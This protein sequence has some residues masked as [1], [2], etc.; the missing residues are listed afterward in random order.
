MKV[1]FVG[2][3]GIGQR[4]LRN[5]KELLGNE[6]E[7]YA[8]RQR[9]Y[10]FVLDNKL[11]IKKGLNLDKHYNIKN[12]NS[13]DE[14]FKKNIDIVFITNPTSMHMEILM[15]AAENKCSIFVEK[16]ISHNL[17]NVDKLVTKLNEYKNITFVGFQNRFHPCIKESKK[18]LDKNV[19]GQIVCV[20]IEIG[21]N[22]RGWHKYEDY[23]KM[24]ASRKD[25]GGGVILSQIH[26][27]DY[28]IWF[29]GMPKCVYAIGGKLSNLEIDV[30]DVASILLNYELNNKNIPV[31]IHEDYIQIP[32]SRKCKIIG[33]KGKIE[34]DL[35][36]STLVY[37]DE[38]GNEMLN[39]VYEFERN[40]MF[41][42]ELK[43]FIDA[44]KDKKRTII[45]I[46]EGIKS[47]KMA[48]AI[49]ESINK[50]NIIN[51]NEI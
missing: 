23:R 4:H 2:L 31:H 19:I 3:G 25:L 38:D 18:L 37:Y 30:E 41:K 1:L 43:V 28:I 49:K 22:V 21:E 46:E 36:N 9:K 32:P 15:K 29:L 10:Q 51:M 6:I 12:V 11:N 24:Y 16:P 27:L 7:V 42:E 34:F 13:L 40:D 45:P 5:I 14:A 44:V 47:L 8:F 26:E 48:I 33:T 17:N 35:L 20:N 50:G 39:K